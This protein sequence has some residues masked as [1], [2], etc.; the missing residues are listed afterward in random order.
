MK[1]LLKSKTFGSVLSDGSFSFLR[2]SSHFSQKELNC[3]SLDINNHTVWTGK[4]TK[5]Q[6]E[7]SLFVGKFTKIF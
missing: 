7:I 4:R 5:N 3:K 1:L 6:T 2:L